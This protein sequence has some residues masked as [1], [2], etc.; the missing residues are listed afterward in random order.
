MV[1]DLHV[2]KELAVCLR[3]SFPGVA[4][5]HKIKKP[6]LKRNGFWYILIE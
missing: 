4:Y 3:A 2:Q 1:S 6:F 5:A